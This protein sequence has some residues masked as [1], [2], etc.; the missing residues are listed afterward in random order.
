M[1]RGIYPRTPPKRL[2]VET[3]MSIVEMRR[4]GE[5]C[6]SICK[7]FRICMATYY[8]II[9]NYAPELVR[10]ASKA[11]DSRRKAIPQTVR[12]PSSAVLPVCDS[13]FIRPPTRAQLMAGSARTRG[14]Y[15]AVC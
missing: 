12:K 10:Y 15:G 13:S 9:H 11:R 1:P 14:S 2:S 4:S 3:K 5:E 8:D 6:E 7:I